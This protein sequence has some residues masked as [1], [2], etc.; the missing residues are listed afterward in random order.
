MD[1]IKIL[2]S[3]EE[4]TPIADEIRQLN[5]T[6]ELMDLNTMINNLDEANS[7]INT[8]ATKLDE[9]KTI[10]AGKASGGGEDVSI[11]TCTLRFYSEDN[12]MKLTWYAYERFSEGKVIIQ[13]VPVYSG[14]SSF[15]ITINDMVCGGLFIFDVTHTYGVVVVA[16]KNSTTFMNADSVYFVRSVALPGDTSII[17]LE[18]DD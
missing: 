11:E 1:S 4:I 6:T 16:E 12:G 18:N 8:Q 3:K 17:R 15:D 2:A 9:L 7:E 10:L 14:G 5:G 13:V